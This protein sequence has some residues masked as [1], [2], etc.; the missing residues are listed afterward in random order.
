M[1]PAL[2]SRL[3]LF[4]AAAIALLAPAFADLGLW[5]PVVMLLG[6]ATMIIGGWR[7]LRQTDL[8]LLLAYGTVSQL[9]FMVMLLGIGT[10]AAALAGLGTVIAHALFKSTL[11]MIVGVI[12]HS[13]G[14]RDL[15]ELNGVGY[16]VPWLAIL[17]G[18]AALSMAGMP[19]LVGFLT[20]EAAFESVVYLVTGD[21]YE[22]TPLAGA[23]LGVAV[24]FGSALTVAYSLRW[25][26]GAFAAKDG[27]PVLTWHRPAL[28]MGAVPMLLGAAGLWLGLRD[29]GG[30]PGWATR[31]ASRRV[32]AG[33]GA[34]STTAWATPT[35]S[36]SLERYA[37]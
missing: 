4:L 1:L 9:G 18:L 16:R 29:R 3:S 37:P 26:W 25:W 19:P 20:K 13:A 14:T 22:V 32:P 6:T 21:V 28:G 8:K 36:S 33:P 12:D 15:R 10:E 35:T 23:A 7:A 30:W 2:P 24:M 27:A 11:F 34:A 17:G 31:Y 5:R